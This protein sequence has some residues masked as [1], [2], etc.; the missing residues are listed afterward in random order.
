MRGAAC[1]QYGASVTL[2]LDD[3]V[4]HVVAA[5]PLTQK[6]KW[7]QQRG[8]HVVSPA[9][10]Q[11]TGASVLGT[12]KMWPRVYWHPA[13]RILG[14]SQWPMLFRHA[15]SPGAGRATASH[16]PS[17]CMDRPLRRTHVFMLVTA[18]LFSQNICQ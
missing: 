15:Q 11:A 14:S 13:S 16:P 8:R 12:L 9:W 17:C 4:T 5:G 6:V 3:E 18:C 7:A 1:A 2:D 10:L